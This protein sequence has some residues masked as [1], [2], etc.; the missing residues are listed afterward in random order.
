MLF[1]FLLRPSFSAHLFLSSFLLAS[2]CSIWAVR[3]KQ[4]E[5]LLGVVVLIT[6]PFFSLHFGTNWEINTGAGLLE[7]K[8][9][10]LFL[11][12][13]IGGY[14]PNLAK[15]PQTT[16]TGLPTRN[17]IPAVL[18]PH[19]QICKHANSQPLEHHHR[20]K[21]DPRTQNQRNA[22]V[23][24]RKGINGEKRLGLSS[25]NA[26]SLGQWFGAQDLWF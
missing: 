7:I 2:S 22:M 16:G 10:P 1:C 8:I 14:G 26:F 20:Q 9:S 11:V 17:Q 23:P 6:T 21:H 13:Y 15:Q 24:G 4:T 18:F 5:Y 19:P 12:R 3:W 25:W